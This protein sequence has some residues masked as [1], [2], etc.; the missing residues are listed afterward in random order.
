MSTIFTGYLN[1]LCHRLAHKA[2]LSFRYASGHTSKTP[3]VK[4][5]NNMT[6]SISDN[7]TC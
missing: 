1:V 4:I 3:I 7:Y 5:C 6:I 2:Y